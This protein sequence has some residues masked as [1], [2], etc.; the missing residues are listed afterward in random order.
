MSALALPLY[1][2]KTPEQLFATTFEQTKQ[3]VT[4]L[5]E[6]HR[7]VLE[8]R[9]GDSDLD[10]PILNIITRNTSTSLARNFW[11]KAAQALRLAVDDSSIPLALGHPVFNECILATNIQPLLD[12]RRSLFTAH[13]YALKILHARSVANTIHT[14][15]DLAS[16]AG[17]GVAGDDDEEEEGEGNAGLEDQLEEAYRRGSPLDDCS[18]K[19]P[20]QAR[21]FPGGF[22]RV[23]VSAGSNNSQ[24]GAPS[25]TSNIDDHHS[26]VK[27]LLQE[28]IQGP[29]STGNLLADRTAGRVAAFRALTS[30]ELEVVASRFDDPTPIEIRKDILLGKYVDLEKIKG[31]VP[32]AE[33]HCILRT[34]STGTVSSKS[35]VPTRPIQDGLRWLS[36]FNKYWNYVFHN[37]RWRKEEFQYHSEWL[38]NR[39][40]ATPT[41]ILNLIALDSDFRRSLKLPGRGLTFYDLPSNVPLQIEFLTRD[42]NPV[43]SS[44]SSNKRS[45]EDEGG[46]WD[47]TLCRK[48]NTSG[49]ADHPL[50]PNQTSC[51]YL[52]QSPCGTPGCCWNNCKHSNR[53]PRPSGGGGESSQKRGRT[54]GAPPTSARK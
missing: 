23:S 45:S 25:N 6:L 10:V 7:Q 5:V 43:S 14:E 48:F 20:A 49:V 28:S 42:F 15:L 19:K 44:K 18:H 21:G 16:V 9:N 53:G 27:N 22:G 39:F 26:F 41:K 3:I 46:K 29:V 30:A 8:E 24:F 2:T 52:H 37:F 31:Y 33:N 17:G 11:N 54:D 34:D 50:A 12:A 32:S 51:T 47:A 35:V 40:S 38:V 36:A 4:A 1:P 13:C